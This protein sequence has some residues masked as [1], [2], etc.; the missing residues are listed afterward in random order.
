MTQ[1]ASKIGLKEI[2][3]EFWF[4]E[5]GEWCIQGLK[6]LLTEQQ[7]WFGLLCPPTQQWCC[8]IF[9]CSLSL[10]KQLGYAFHN[11]HRY[12]SW[13]FIFLYCTAEQG[14]G[15]NVAVLYFKVLCNKDYR[16]VLWVMSRIVTA[17]VSFLQDEKDEL[18]KVDM[19]KYDCIV[20]R[21]YFYG[22]GA[23]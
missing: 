21:E 13:H 10:C 15:K 9:S 16:P 3:W 4:A 11:I 23:W 5:R 19:L 22:S 17:D 6:V 14:L 8:C 1:R 2:Q 20:L 7:N 12:F 18:I